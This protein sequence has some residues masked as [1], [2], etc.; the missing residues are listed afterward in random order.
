MLLRS[1]RALERALD[2]LS[3]DVTE[4]QDALST[5]AAP[6]RHGQGLARVAD[7]AGR[8]GAEPQPRCGGRGLLAV[9]CVSCGS[10]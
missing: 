2:A 8:P 3:S 5:H 4:L 7:L 10:I 9:S 6:Q 1:A